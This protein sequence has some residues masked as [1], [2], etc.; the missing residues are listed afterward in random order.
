MTDSKNSEFLFVETLVIPKKAFLFAETIYTNN[1]ANCRVRVTWK[2][3]DTEKQ[4][5]DIIV[6]HI[7]DNKSDHKITHK[8]A[9][10]FAKEILQNIYQQLSE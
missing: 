10:K 5:K 2:N 4:Y 9:E 1:G 7:L 6:F 8:D 3:G